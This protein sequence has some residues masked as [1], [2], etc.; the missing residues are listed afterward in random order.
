MCGGGE[1]LHDRRQ[2]NHRCHRVQGDYGLFAGSLAGFRHYL[3]EGKM[4]FEPHS[5]EVRV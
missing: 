2:A 1:E 4:N 3:G 5:T